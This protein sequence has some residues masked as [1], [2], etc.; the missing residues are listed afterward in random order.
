MK[1]LAWTMAVVLLFAVLTPLGVLTV[2]Q[3]D[4]APGNQQLCPVMGFEI[5]RELFTDYQGKR[6]YFCCPSCPPEFKKTPDTYMAAMEADGVV[7]EDAPA[8]Q[9]EPK[10]RTS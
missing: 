3:V 9:A 6:V 7:P 8:A 2:G 4:A 1:R 10:Q 5:N